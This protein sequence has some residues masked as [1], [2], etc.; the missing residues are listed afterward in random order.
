[1]GAGISIPIE[2]E[3][4][5]HSPPTP[6]DVRGQLR[7]VFST[8]SWRPR[9]LE[10]R[11]LM[12]LL[13]A[14]ERSSVDKQHRL[15]DR[16][17]A[18]VSRLM[19]RRCVALCLGVP[20]E[21]VVVARTKGDKPFDATPAGGDARAATSR[22]NFNFNV[23]HEGHYVVLASEPVLLVGIDV[24]APFEIRDAGNITNNYESLRDTFG[25]VLGEDEWCLVEDEGLS[26]FARATAFRRQWSRKE[27]LV[28]RVATASPFR[29]LRR[30]SGRV[31][32]PSRL[33]RLLLLLLTVRRQLPLLLL[34]LLL[35]LRCGCG[36]G[37]RRRRS[38]RA[39]LWTART[40]RRL[41]RHLLLFA[42]HVDQRR[43]RPL[44]LTAPSRHGRRA[45]ANAHGELER[46]AL[47]RM[48]YCHLRA[49]GRAHH[50]HHSRPGELRDRCGRRLQE[51]L[52][53]SNH[54][55][56]R[57]EEPPRVTTTAFKI[58]LCA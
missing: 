56:Q 42:W 44:P 15:V 38:C 11:F 27:S 17:R 5:D 7:W 25:N 43:P 1:M 24:S 46:R 34:L 57:A 58:G 51:D 54:E 22:P 16:Q 9:A 37:R 50:F 41:H 55:P 23:S 2:D 8:R 6:I 35:L 26:D 52:P 36:G 21:A 4:L 28:R 29:S 14:A 3:H 33:Y 45:D 39:R 40:S 53:T 30:A 49:A 47:P 32:R 19:Q 12:S 10:W 31:I 13:P 20:D 18:L 48:A